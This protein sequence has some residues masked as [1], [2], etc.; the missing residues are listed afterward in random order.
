[1]T[2]V[3]ALGGIV[4]SAMDAIIT[5]DEE[6]RVVLFNAAAERIFRWPRRPCRPALEMLL[7]ERFRPRTSSTS[8]GSA[9][10]R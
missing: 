7:P 10:P 3:K 4:E 1:L 2:P 6:Q 9:R 5:V 8:S